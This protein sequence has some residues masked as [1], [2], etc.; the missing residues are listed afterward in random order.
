MDLS[1]RS[2][3]SLSFRQGITT[4]TPGVV[5]ELYPANAIVS[6]VVLNIARLGPRRLANNLRFYAAAAGAKML[7]ITSCNQSFQQATKE[8][9]RRL[10]S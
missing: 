1:V 9:M 7:E 10:N 3:W 8:K 4:D 2:I 5:S 6:L